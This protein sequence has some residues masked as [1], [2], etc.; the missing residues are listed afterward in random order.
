MAKENRVIQKPSPPPVRHAALIDPDTG[1]ISGYIRG[2][3]FVLD[4]DTD[5]NWRDITG[6]PGADK[7]ANK[8]INSVF[9]RN[10]RLREKPKIKLSVDSRRIEIGNG[11]ANLTMEV[12]GSTAFLPEE[13]SVSINGKN[14]TM[15]LD[16]ALDIM[17]NS[18]QTLK[19]KIDDPRVYST[20]IILVHAVPAEELILPV[21][22]DARASIVLEKKNG[23]TKR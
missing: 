1:V 19:I 16:Q 6:V 2:T 9:L 12:D 13:I 18:R 21:R 22:V 10:G 4:G 15:K 11:R 14:E 8:D 20:D 7:L 3:N 23:Q 17:S 5:A